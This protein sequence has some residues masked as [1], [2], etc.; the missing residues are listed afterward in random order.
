MKQAIAV[1]DD[2]LHVGI[3]RYHRH[4]IDDAAFE[5]T[6]WRIILYEF[7]FC[8]EYIYKRVFQHY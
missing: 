2:R 1:F 5:L 4:V 3:W 7:T 8:H 6:S